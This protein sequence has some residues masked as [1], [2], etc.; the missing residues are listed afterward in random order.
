MNAPESYKQ[1]V[2]ATQLAAHECA[3]HWAAHDETYPQEPH[4]CS[5]KDTLD[6]ALHPDH[7]KAAAERTCSLFAKPP[8]RCDY[9][10]QCLLPIALP[11]QFRDYARLISNSKRDA[12]LAEDNLRK[13]VGRPYAEAEA[14]AAE[15]G[16]TCTCGSPLPKRR[17]L[18]DSC[19]KANRK[20]AYRDAKA[21]NHL[22]VPQLTDSA[23]LD[24]TGVMTRPNGKADQ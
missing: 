19:A 21:K 10:E 24:T 4:R 3:N 17:R 8:T 15:S 13:A 1:Y 7:D 20:K 22:T 6:L 12:R 23:P 9:F 16:R 5:Q 14:E 11:N 2:N 18:C